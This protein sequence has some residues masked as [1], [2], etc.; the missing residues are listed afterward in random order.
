VNYEVNEH[1]K[2]GKHGISRVL[3]HEDIEFLL[4]HFFRKDLGAN[5]IG[6]DL[7]LL[8]QV[9]VDGAMVVG[10]HFSLCIGPIGCVVVP[11]A[12]NLQWSSQVQE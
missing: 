8:L 4:E 6:V 11:Y 3:L 1:E 5:S 12:L 10:G 2:H 9:C 7:S